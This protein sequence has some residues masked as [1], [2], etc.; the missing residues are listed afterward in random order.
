MITAAP[1]SSRQRVLIVAFACHPDLNMETRI[2]WNRAVA[3]AR[4][5]DTTVFHSPEFSSEELSRKA[6]SIGIPASS[7]RFVAVK[8]W[9]MSWPMPCDAIYWAGY[10]A[11]HDAA[12]KVAL[13][14]HREN[15]FLLVHLVSYCGY[16]EPGQWWKLGIPFI[17]GPIGGTQNFPMSFFNKLSFGSSIREAVRNYMNSWQLHYSR[18]VQFAAQKAHTVFAASSQA[19]RDLLCGT[20]VQSKRLLET[21]VS[22]IY[23]EPDR[24]LD[25]SRPFRILWSGRLREW[26]ALPLLLEALAESSSQLK[27]ELRVMGVGASEKRW[28]KVAERLKIGQNVQWIG[29]PSYHEGLEQYSWAD[30]FAFTSLRDTSGT[31]LLESLAAGTPIIGVDHQGAHDIMTRDCSIPISVGSPALVVQG[32][33]DAIVQ[34]AGAPALWRRLSEGAVQRTSHFSWERLSEQIDAAY[35]EALPLQVVP[36]EIS[37]A[38]LCESMQTPLMAGSSRLIS[39]LRH[40]MK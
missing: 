8:S 27:F 18:R 6:E 13:A 23:P 34:L 36:E 17:W 16:R 22:P 29:W 11:W 31:G 25:T 7:L 37:Q 12:L 10:R 40:S 15:P 2:G 33:K 20:G 19:Q 39:G 4:D 38:D 30:V 5:Y 3:S 32:F 1:T 24:H 14:M 28:R 26:K 9:M 21:A 35:K